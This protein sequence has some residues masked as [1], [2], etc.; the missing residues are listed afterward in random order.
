MKKKIFALFLSLCMVLTM[1]PSMGFASTV[2]IGVYANLNGTT[3]IANNAVNNLNEFYVI[4]DYTPK[5]GEQVAFYTDSI[6]G[7]S[8]TG[9]QLLEN[10]SKPYTKIIVEGSFSDQEYNIRFC[11]INSGNDCETTLGTITVTIN[12]EVS[13]SDTTEPA[14]SSERQLLYVI[15]DENVDNGGNVTTSNW[16]NAVYIKKGGSRSPKYFGIT[17]TAPNEMQSGK[18]YSF[19]IVTV[20]TGT[21]DDNRLT[22]QGQSGDYRVTVS[23]NAELTGE[24]DEPYKA[25]IDIEGKSYRLDYC[26]EAVSSGEDSETDS[27]VPLDKTLLVC[28]SNDD[29]T[30]FT[31]ISVEKDEYGVEYPA[32]YFLENNTGDDGKGT[33]YVLCN[34]A[35]NSLN[36]PILDGFLV[37]TDDRNANGEDNGAEITVEKVNETAGDTS[38]TAK[39]VRLY[40]ET[41]SV[42]K[43]TVLQAFD[44]A[45]RVGF[46]FGTDNSTNATLHQYNSGDSDRKTTKFMWILGRGYFETPENQTSDILLCDFLPTNN[47]TYSNINEV[48]N[49][50]KDEIKHINLSADKDAAANTFY[51][52]Y[53][54]GT[55][56]S[57]ISYKQSLYEN[58]GKGMSLG[59]V[60]KR[61][62]G[63]FC[64]NIGEIYAKTSVNNFTVTIGSTEYVA[65]KMTLK[66]YYGHEDILSEFSISG[67]DETRS[68]T[69]RLVKGM[70][71]AI[72]DN[73][74]GVAYLNANVE[75][76]QE[77]MGITPDSE[78][79]FTT[80]NRAFYPNACAEV[81]EEGRGR[82]IEMNLE[83]E[84]GYVLEKI[85]DGGKELAY[86][87]SYCTYY[88]IYD[89][90][91]KEIT[92][93]SFWDLMGDELCDDIRCAS[94]D[95]ENGDS[96]G[97]VM[98][99]HNFASSPQ[100][101]RKEFL[102]GEVGG[103]D[104][105][106][107]INMIKETGYSLKPVTSFT[108]YA[109]YY[110]PETDSSKKEIVFHVKKAESTASDISAKNNG[111]EETLNVS[112]AEAN[113]ATK[114]LLKD[115]LTKI[116]TRGYEVLDVYDM[117]RADGNEAS[118]LYNI[119][120]PASKLSGVDPTKCKV[121]YYADNGKAV[122][123]EMGT[124]YTTD[125]N[126]NPNG[127]VFTTG[128]FSNYAVIYEPTKSSSGGSGG[129]AIQS[130]D[131]VTNKTE[132]KTADTSA[133]T[134]ATVKN[135][136]TTAAD[137]TKTV[138]AKVDSATADKIVKKAVE[139]KSAEVVV[140]AA[141]KSEVTETA[142]GTKTEVTLPATTVAGIANK[143]EA[144]VII[145]ADA[146]EIKLDKEAVKAVA[147]AAG[148]A[149]EVKLEVETVAQD[150]NKVQV[151][152]KLVTS[153]G[154]I[155]DF[156]GGNVSVTVKLNAALAAKP[157]VCVYIDAHSTYHKVGGQKNP[158]G[159]F[160]FKTGHFSSYAVMAEEE[161]DKVIAEQTA[162]VEKLVSTL[163]LKARSAKTAKGYIKVTLTADHDAIKAIEDL[164]YTVKYKFYRSTKKAKGYKAAVEKT[165]K[166]YTNTTGKKGT[167]YYYKA[168]VMVYDAQGNLVTESALTQCKY[169]C[170]SK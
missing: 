148:T 154:N 122:P 70:D 141:T 147:E 22:I 136:T 30:T 166:S 69:L 43:V 124:T 36:L 133:T 169:A 157:V 7:I 131:T 44:E 120:I 64:Q 50:I 156:K 140:D 91:G 150:E 74:E 33:F 112:D 84:P 17:T 153:A 62:G 111:D 10:N 52:L 88:R 92:G 1:M 90:E 165:A 126:G 81:N 146:A 57:E 15:Y 99:Y 59:H 95:D 35:A 114:T 121:V 6:S 104:V 24:N 158:D 168:R 105:E 51:V 118:G 151:D 27:Y 139:N 109:I 8:G 161:A 116:G 82:F 53:P 129:S 108:S 80:D 128:H 159:T 72:E 101:Y 61:P 76:S 127:I 119:T 60:T 45:I 25:N 39:T 2:T 160:T 94:N 19:K 73:A 31:P 21:Y 135:T 89:R 48:P 29:G 23:D 79:K 145:K 134:T 12:K 18:E 102:H 68:T 98:L 63:G 4:A 163:S 14:E 54:Q 5:Q 143:T 34:N 47:E 97:F 138:A 28:T 55:T 123:L 37:P 85:T 115:N 71:I 38:Q 130:T 40:D 78:L 65:Q 117:K 67:N 49:T 46:S 144:A 152:L 96:I 137:G 42:W 125:G 162:K 83:L 13:G 103:N 110:N 100:N 155:S 170:R 93:N 106:A 164:G 26:V 75:F 20:Q 142:A 86:L 107:I 149:G 56:L 113:A 3:P 41:Y 167:K 58:N 132:D 16:E 66:N 9:T 11:T 87:A 77:K 32:Q